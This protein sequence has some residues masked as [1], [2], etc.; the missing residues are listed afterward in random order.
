MLTCTQFHNR[1]SMRGERVVIRDVTTNK[2][3]LYSTGPISSVGSY[4]GFKA[5][6]R[7]NKRA[8]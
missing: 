3:G 4:G 2:K 5:T 6:A 1:S 8:Y 7:K